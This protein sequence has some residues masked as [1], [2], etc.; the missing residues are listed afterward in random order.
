MVRTSGAWLRESKAL[1]LDDT[2]IAGLEYTLPENWKQLWM[3]PLP[4][5]LN[6]LT[7]KKFSAS[8]NL[9]IDIDP[10]FPWQI[11]ALDGYG[12]N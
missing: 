3:K 5:W 4:D 11:T 6:S 12:A 1:I 9:V 10:A 8:R 2:A 7:L